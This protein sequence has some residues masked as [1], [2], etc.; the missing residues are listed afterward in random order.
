[1][2]ADIDTLFWQVILHPDSLLIQMPGRLNVRK[3]IAGE[4]VF[5][6]T[7]PQFDR[8]EASLCGEALHPTG[9]KYDAFTPNYDPIEFYHF[10]GSNRFTGLYDDYLHYYRRKGICYTGN[11][12]DQTCRLTLDEIRQLPKFYPYTHYILGLPVQIERY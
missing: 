9:N 1:M 2:I 3:L 7:E 12:H 11:Y 4:Q 10:L 5:F 6:L 8:L